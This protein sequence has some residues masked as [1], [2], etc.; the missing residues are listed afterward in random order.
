MPVEP[1][2]N[3]LRDKGL[4]EHTYPVWSYNNTAARRKFECSV[5]GASTTESNHHEVTM[6][7]R[8][9]IQ[10]H[11]TNCLPEGYVCA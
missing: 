2:R 3:W 5:C 9:F 4:P 8:H 6:R 11:D 10:Q 1:F 7:T